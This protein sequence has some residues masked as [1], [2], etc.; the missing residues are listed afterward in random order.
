MMRINAQHLSQEPT[1]SNQKRPTK[2]TYIHQKRP[3]QKT[4]KYQKRPTEKTR[5]QQKMLR[6]KDDYSHV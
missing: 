6:I 4:S 1:H 5:R 2:E 3:T